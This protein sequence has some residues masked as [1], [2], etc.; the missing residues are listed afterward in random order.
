M[1]FFEDDSVAKLLD[2]NAKQL[3]SLEESESER[4]LRRYKEIRRALRDRLDTL[5]GDTFTAQQL[6]GV[7]VQVESAI[8]EMSR[9][10]KLEMS[11]SAAEVSELSVNHLTKEIERF[12]EMFTGAV[13][14]IGIDL[15]VIVTQTNNL[16]IDKHEAS[17]DAYS[18]ALR[19]Q[20]AGSLS[21]AVIEKVSLAEVVKRLSSFFI[22]EEWKLLRIARTELHGIY[23]TSKL[24][25][26]ESVRDESLPDLMKA[27]W[28]PIDNRTGE[29]SKDLARKDPVVPVD[30]PFVQRFGGREYVFMAP[31]NRPND[32]AVLIPYRKAWDQA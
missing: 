15:S 25:G 1:S 9:S 17:L 5:R 24:L 20:I 21:Q 22:G 2:R 14:P 32:R 28:H 30:K 3:E 4:I 12:D 6:R 27:L 8:L 23:S 16:L 19:S 10:L 7:L 31:P 18:S 26:M 11:E 29:D 13:T